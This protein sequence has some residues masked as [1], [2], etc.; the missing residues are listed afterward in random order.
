MPDRDPFAQQL[1][2][3]RQAR[4]ESQAAVATRAG[5]SREWLC[6]LEASYHRPNLATLRLWAS[7]MGMELVLREVPDA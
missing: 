2:D 4:G 6:Q 5:M 3:R 7:A 1:R